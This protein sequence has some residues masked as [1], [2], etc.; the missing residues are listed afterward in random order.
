MSTYNRNLLK[1]IMA[2]MLCALIFIAYTPGMAYALEEKAI[3]AAVQERTAEEASA[4]PDSD[5]PDSDELLWGYLDKAVT[6][7]SMSGRPSGKSMLRSSAATRRSK[8]D[9]YNGRVYDILKDQITELINPGGGVGFVAPIFNVPFSDILGHELT[10]TSLDTGNKVIDAYEVSNEDLRI[11]E[12]VDGFKVIESLM[13]DMPYELYWFDKTTPF[14][15]VWAPRNY[16]VD[17]EETTAYFEYAP[18]LQ[19]TMYVSAEYSYSGEPGT[20]DADISKLRA[21]KNT[22]YNAEEIIDS[23]K[24]ESD[25][26]KLA[27]YRDAVCRRTSYNYDAAYSDDYSYGDPWQ[28]I[29]V[30]DNDDTTDVVCEGYSKAF[31]FLCDH[32]NFSN[33]IECDSVTGDMTGRTGSGGHMWNILH[34]EDGR[35][36]IADI[37]NSD[38]GMSGANGGL[39]ISPAL[40]GGN[41]SEGYQYDVNGDEAADIK[42]EYD[43]KTRNLFS[44]S[45]LTMSTLPYDKEDPEDPDHSISFKDSISSEYLFSDETDRKLTLNTDKLDQDP[46]VQGYEI[47]FVVRKENKDWT[48]QDGSDRWQILENS[49]DKTY[50]SVNGKELSLNGETIYAETG[51]A[52]ISVLAEIIRNGDKITDCESLLHTREAE[53]TLVGSYRSVTYKERPDGSRFDNAVVGYV[54]WTYEEGVLTFTGNGEMLTPDY[55]FDSSVPN[56]VICGDVTGDYWADHLA[57]W[58]LKKV[59]IASDFDLIGNRAFMDLGPA[60]FTEVEI[61]GHIGTVGEYCFLDADK[62]TLTGTIDE[63]MKGAFGGASDIDLKGSILKVSQEKDSSVFIFAQNIN[64][65]PERDIELGEYVFYDCKAS[66]VEIPGSVKT[67]APGLFLESGQLIKAELDPGVETIGRRAFERCEKLRSVGIPRSVTS[68]D[69][70]AFQDTNLETVYY[71]GTEEEWERAGLGSSFYE[72]VEIIY[73]SGSESKYVRNMIDQIG[74]V[75]LARAGYIEEMRKLYDSLWKYQK[76]SFPPESLDVLEK[77]EARLYTIGWDDVTL[78]DGVL[79]IG[80]TG[81]MDWYKEEPPWGGQI[82]GIHKIVIGDGMTSIKDLA[83]RNSGDLKEIE[84]PES[85]ESIGVDAFYNTGI[86]ELVIPSGVKTIGQGAFRN[87][88]IRKIVIPDGVEVLPDNCMQYNSWLEVVCLPAGIREIGDNVFYSCGPL[89]SED[90]PVKTVGIMFGGSEEEWNAIKKG[91]DDGD[92][93]KNAT[94]YF[95]CRDEYDAFGQSAKKLAAMDQTDTGMLTELFCIIHSYKEFTVEERCALPTETKFAI[96][97]LIRSYGQRNR[98]NYSWLYM[99]DSCIEVPEG[100]E[101]VTAG[102]YND[103]VDLH[104][105][106][107]PDSVRIIGPQAFAGCTDLIDIELPAGLERIDAGAFEGCGCLTRI[108]FRGTQED[109]DNIVIDNAGQGNHILQDAE[110]YIECNDRVEALKKKVLAYENVSVDS[111]NAEDVR[112]LEQLCQS[113][114]EEEYAQILHGADTGEIFFRLI[115]ELSYYDQGKPVPID[116][117]KVEVRF[118]KEKYPYNGGLEIIPVITIAGLVEGV[119]YEVMYFDN[120]NVG[121]AEAYIQSKNEETCCNSRSVYFE[122]VDSDPG[123]WTVPPYT[124][125][126][127]SNYDAEPSEI[128]DLPAV[129]ISKPAAAKKKITVKW[130]KVSKKNLKKISGIQIQVATDPGFTNIVKATTAGKK[131]TSKVIKGLQP[132]TKYYVRIRAYA[133]GDHYS[134]W[135]TKSA[136]VK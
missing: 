3:S 5:D 87:T 52:K 97:K 88:H 132:K 126:S 128:I 42:Y 22:I 90:P 111:N 55:H 20:T 131:K 95:N 110:L 93:L 77:A 108:F 32:T 102:A 7:L 103:R 117:G 83:F 26:S 35:N 1:R 133:P 47:S 84:M 136:K 49:A 68:I 66:H 45:E 62:L 63:A 79:T 109:W 37:T 69:L 73:N 56:V 94:V 107:V 125:N 11:I 118:D 72:N 54:Y 70:S 9:E 91:A 58:D 57:E 127:Y 46:E 24:E 123:T 15:Y 129:K 98:E 8:L 78:E 30:F 106:H 89:I 124:D 86:S 23:L 67:I 19:F 43:S 75:T 65:D 82:R 113:L 122:I 25:Y 44:E 38:E 21:V 40:K 12:N 92:F 104:S 4:L 74:T 80:Y 2:T 121:M 120:C 134:V 76:N 99:D 33:D 29:Y 116:L 101:T 53:E 64:I 85:L 119:D 28:M 31:Q 81:P 71:E 50:Y 41:V 18:Y 60:S 10:T 112:K 114:P 51:E 13:A 100:T 115:D 16:W 48:E 17:D 39:F 59:V 14:S 105:I 96:D 27:G 61:Q 36:Y 6:E 135:K 34:M 130:K